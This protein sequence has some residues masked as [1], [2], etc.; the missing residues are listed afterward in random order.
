MVKIRLSLKGKKNQHSYWLE[1]IDER[2]SR[3]SGKFLEYLGF[4]DPIKKKNN[5]EKYL[6]NIKKWI[7]K[8]AKPSKTVENLIKKIILKKNLK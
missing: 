6:P 4:Y 1:A 3:D 8:G 5:I 7:S 2:K